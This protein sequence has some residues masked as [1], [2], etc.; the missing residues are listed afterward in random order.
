MF[1][2]PGNSHRK[3]Q[4]QWVNPTSMRKL[5]ACQLSRVV[6]IKADELRYAS[7]QV[8]KQ[9]IRRP[10][11]Q[12]NSA[13]HWA[14]T[15]WPHDWPRKLIE[16]GGIRPGGCDGQMFLATLISVRRGEKAELTYL[17]VSP[18][19]YKNIVRFDIVVDD[20]VGVYM[21]QCAEDTMNDGLYLSTREGASTVLFVYGAVLDIFHNYK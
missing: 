16:R 11:R 14:E 13:K 21:C 8:V 15:R 20:S 2:K 10:M 3:Q 1:S 12:D 17:V 7:L 18:C 6:F 5:K 9:E 19:M 4:L